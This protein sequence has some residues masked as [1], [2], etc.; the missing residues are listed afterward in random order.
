[1]EYLS[2]PS[3]SNPD[4][5]EVN[6]IDI[7]PSWIDPIIG[8]LTMGSLLIEK[9]EARCIK[10]QLAKYNIINGVLYE[11]GYTLPTYGAYGPSYGHLAKNP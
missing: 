4:D 8:Y 2:E 9:F 3:V 5:I 7:G 1:M 6:S 11:R 10:Y